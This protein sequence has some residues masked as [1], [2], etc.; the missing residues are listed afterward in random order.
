[1]LAASALLF[2]TAF[3][4]ATPLPGSSELLLLA[5][6]QAGLNPAIL[7][8]AASLGNVLGAVLNWWLGLK[9]TSFSDRPWFPFKEQELQRGAHWYARYGRWSLLLSWLPVI[10]DAI[11]IAAGA[12]G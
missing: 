1:M 7:W 5:Q 8:L 3:A 9:F 2:F 10:G 4:C 12:L 6:L 11:T